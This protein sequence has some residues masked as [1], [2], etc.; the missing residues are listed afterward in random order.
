[1]KTMTRPPR[2]RRAPRSAQRVQLLFHDLPGG[3]LGR[4]AT[5]GIQYHSEGLPRDTMRRF[6]VYSLVFVLEGISQYRDDHGLRRELTAGDMLL[7]FPDLGHWYGP[8]RGSY[9]NYLYAVFEG[10]VFDLW[11]KQGLLDERDPVLR[12]EPMGYWLPRIR[13]VLNDI[14]VPGEGR[15]LER[16]CRMQS[17]LADVLSQ[18]RHDKAQAE[19]RAWLL[20]ACLKLHSKVLREEQ[21]WEDIAREL[22]MSYEGFRRRFTHL[23]GI[24]PARYCARSRVQKACELMYQSDKPIK[25]VSEEAG[26]ENE[27]HFSRKFKQFTGLS[28]REFRRRALAGENVALP[29]RGKEGRG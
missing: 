16:V 4:V 14:A 9:A 27:F 28:P 24:S 22:G 6:G 10:P 18:R 25:Q 8:K 5:A 12:L 29:R 20:R 15:E 13:G 2:R 17:L 7:V 19:K 11:R 21:E 23:A 3:P 1:M 26:F